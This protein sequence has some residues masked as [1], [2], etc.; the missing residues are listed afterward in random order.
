MAANSLDMHVCYHKGEPIGNCE[1]FINGTVAKIEDFDI[2]DAYQRKGF[3]TSVLKH[4][5]RKAQGQGAEWVYLIT[6]DAETAKEMYVK[7]GLVLAGQ[8]TQLHFS[9]TYPYGE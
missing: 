8:K 1:L 5:V 2:L 9:L 4:L 6:D 3:G 7:S